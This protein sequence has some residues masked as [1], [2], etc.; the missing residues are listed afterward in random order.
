MEAQLLRGTS[1]VSAQ[2]Q[3]IRLRQITTKIGT[4][5]YRQFSRLHAVDLVAAVNNIETELAQWRKDFP[6]LP[7]PRNPYE[8]AQWRDLNYFRE[9]LHCSRFLVLSAK[10]PGDSNDHD[11]LTGNLKTTITTTGEIADL[12]QELRSAEKLVL[13]WTCVH[14]MMSVGFSTL[15]CGITY[16][17][18][19]RAGQLPIQSLSNIEVDISKTI[20]TTVATLEYIA[21]KWPTVKRHFEVFQALAERVFAFIHQVQELE[22]RFASAGSTEAGPSTSAPGPDDFAFAMGGADDWDAAMAAFLHEPFDWNSID[23]GAMANFDAFG[24]SAAS[25]APWM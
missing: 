7:K 3:Q 16:G 25:S 9:R 4:S 19:A 20:G 21:Q 22:S 2:L 8:S 11:Q 24:L 15:Y 13:N 10:G 5:L 1:E 23:W 12:Y 6:V 14:D 18:M 17:K